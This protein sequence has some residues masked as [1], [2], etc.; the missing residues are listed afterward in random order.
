MLAPID[1]RKIAEP[2]AFRPRS[3]HYPDSEFIRSPTSHFD[4]Y[5]SDNY[6]SVVGSQHTGSCLQ[7]CRRPVFPRTFSHVFL[8]AVPPRFTDEAIRA[9]C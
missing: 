1:D 5:H 6:H 8:P 9:L 3:D 7:Y 4:L 2:H